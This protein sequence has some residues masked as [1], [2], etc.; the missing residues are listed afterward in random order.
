APPFFYGGPPRSILGLCQGLQATRVDVQVMTTTAAGPSELP[1]A[2]HE[3]RICE[4]VPAHYFPLVEPR[5]VWNAAALRRALARDITSFDLVHIHGLWH[6]PGW[7]AARLARRR[8]V[9]YV[10]SPRGML[11]RE[12][13]AI[14]SGR[15][16][17]AFRLI[18]RRRLQS[19]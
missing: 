14:S 3:P 7:D 12:A 16:A 19:A 1:P 11:E 17:V 6:L 10:V 15:K 18:E 9:P 4:G 2:E 8:G 13:L 5:R